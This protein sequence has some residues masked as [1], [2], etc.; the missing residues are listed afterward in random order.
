MKLS[1]YVGNPYLKPTFTNT[2]ELSHIFKNKIT[3][4]VSYNSTTDIIEETIDL[5]NSIYIS[6][7]ANIGKSSVLGLSITGSFKTAKWWTTTL[8]AE[9]QNR[10]YNG[11]VYDYSLDTSS[12]YFGTNMTNQFTLGKGWS[13]E[14]G[15]NYRTGILYGQIISG[16][17]GRVNAGFSKRVLDNKGSV[18]LNFRD[19]F[20]TG[21]NHGI[22][23]SIKGAYPTYHNWGDTQ[24]FVFSFSYNFGKTNSS[25]RARNSG[26]ESEQNR[27]KN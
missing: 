11:I 7:P 4:T 17:T 16:G 10:T 6:R 15:G 13:A 25:P 21:L 9:T 20:R 22:I 8:F 27:I 2:F 1:I 12:V 19:I 5:A 23:T 18:K 3:T 14:L 26:A 24:N